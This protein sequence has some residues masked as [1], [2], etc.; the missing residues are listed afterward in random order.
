MQNS[1]ATYRAT[2]LASLRAMLLISQELTPAAVSK[3]CQMVTRKGGVT[4]T[5]VWLLRS[6]VTA[7]KR[8]PGHP[9]WLAASRKG[10]VSLEKM[11]PTDCEVNRRVTCRRYKEQQRVTRGLGAKQRGHRAQG[12]LQSSQWRL[13]T[14]MD[15]PSGAAFFVCFC[16]AWTFLPSLI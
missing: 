15:T 14:W 3:G 6:T 1:H 5:S 7:R 4:V 16:I 10:T 2:S 13:F 8:Q 9:T 12:E 11:K